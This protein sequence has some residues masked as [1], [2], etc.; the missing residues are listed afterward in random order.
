MLGFL[1]DPGSAGGTGDILL[2]AAGATTGATYDITLVLT[3]S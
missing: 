3:L 2:T 1:S